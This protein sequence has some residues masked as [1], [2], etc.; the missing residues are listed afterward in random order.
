MQA[1]FGTQASGYRWIVLAV[2]LLSCGIYYFSLESIPPLLI[3]IESVFNIGAGTA[4]LLTS[5]IVIPGLFMAIPAGFLINKQGFRTI[6]FLSLICISLG[7]LVIALSTS[8]FLLLCGGFMMGFGS[9]FLTI[10][11]AAMIANWFKSKELGLAMGI[12]S[13]GYPLATIIAFLTVPLMQ[14]SLGWHSSFYLNAIIA[15]LCSLFFLVTVKDTG[16]VVESRMKSNSTVEMFTEYRLVW[17]I[18]LIWLLY[19]MASAA[20]VTWAPSI[21]SIYKNL[22]ILSASLFSSLFLVSELLFIPFYGWA[23]DRYGN[24]RSLMISGLIGMACGVVA[25]I[26]LNGLMLIPVIIMIGAFGSAVPA[27]GTSLD[28]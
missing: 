11:T 7:N 3:K 20:F 25:L 18:G 9:C 8:F 16:L 10:G 14:L 26:Y 19:S 21:L 2:L 4:G 28:G 12:F 27:L 22:S 17:K 1:G 13:I 23:S 6:G 15:I 24:R 5:F